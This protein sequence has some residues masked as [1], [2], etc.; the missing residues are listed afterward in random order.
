M[1]I[2]LIEENYLG[3]SLTIV[4]KSGNKIQGEILRTDEDSDFIKLK[5]ENGITIVGTSAI[6]SIY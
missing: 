5:T 6:E 3:T 4:T 2:K 1:N